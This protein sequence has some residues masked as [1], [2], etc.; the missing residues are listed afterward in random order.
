MFSLRFLLTELLDTIGYVYEQKMSDQTA[1][2]DMPVWDIG[3]R[4]DIRMHEP[5][6]I[7][8]ELCD[9]RRF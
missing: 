9:K 8:K 4:I 1:Q 3:L 7:E 5:L 2:I 6:Q